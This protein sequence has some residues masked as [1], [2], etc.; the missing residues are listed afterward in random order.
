MTEVLLD[1]ISFGEAPRWHDG[2]LWFSDFYSHEVISVDADGRRVETLSIPDQ[3]SGLGWTPSGELLIVSML[4]QAVL[5]W[6]GSALHPFADLSGLAA[7]PC[8]DMVVD[9]EGGAYVGNFGFDRHRGEPERE[10]VL[11][12]VDPDGTASAAAEQLL[13][14][15]GMVITPESE[16]LIVAET[17]RFRLT[18]FD[19]AA[20]GTLSARR[21]WAE[22]GD[23][24]P[25]GICLDAEGAIWVADAG[26]NQVVR[27][28]DGGEVLQRVELDE[29]RK[30]F[31][32]MLG[33]EDRT[34]L[35]IV[36]NLTSGPPAAATRKGRIEYVDVSV[37]GAGLP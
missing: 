37:P 8:N 16:S 12:R 4:D 20:D 10:T 19:L 3:P 33:G 13:F 9:S 26:A 21:T 30:G 14:P 24:R 2:Q 15:N 27:V 36:S 31:A 18:A 5:R 17:F 32:C 23:V 35:Y 28:A 6:D 34:R 29:D 7:G 25:D 11:I 1:D 22:L